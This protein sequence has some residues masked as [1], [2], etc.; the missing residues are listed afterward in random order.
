M[1]PFIFCDFRIIIDLAK[2][3]SLFQAIQIVFRHAHIQTLCL[4]S[5]VVT[6]TD[7]CRSHNIHTHIYIY[8]NTHLFSSHEMLDISDVSS[9]LYHTY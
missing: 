9:S 6:Y 5:R 4:D 7:G 8:K 2:A 3:L 1:K